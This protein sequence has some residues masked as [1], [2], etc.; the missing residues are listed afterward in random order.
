M[1]GAAE[2]RRAAPRERMTAQQRERAARRL[3]WARGRD[4]H[5]ASRLADALEVTPHRLRALRRRLERGEEPCP[6]RGRPRLPD[7]ERARVRELVERE[8]EC[9]GAV[10]WRCVLAGI[11]RREG[12]RPVS[13]MLVQQETAS[14]KR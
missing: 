4:P 2:A 14:A 12:E 8:L 1:S 6:K 3:L 7:E 13:T 5:L 9:Q 10:G 11:E